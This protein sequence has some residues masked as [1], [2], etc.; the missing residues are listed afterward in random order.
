[1]TRAKQ[2]LIVTYVDKR[3]EYEK[4]RSKFLVELG[5]EAEETEA[6]TE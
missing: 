4:K 2:K 6:E 3:G 5:V 1:M